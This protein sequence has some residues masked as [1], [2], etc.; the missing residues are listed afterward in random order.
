LSIRSK[1]KQLKVGTYEVNKNRLF[2][3]TFGLIM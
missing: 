2:E 1:M 3:Y